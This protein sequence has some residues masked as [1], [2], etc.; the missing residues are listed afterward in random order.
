MSSEFDTL[1]E[2]KADLKTKIREQKEKAAEN[3]YDEKLI[4]AMLEHFEADIP[5]V[6]IEAQIDRHCRGLWV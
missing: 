4:D 1:D 2:L 5:E 3:E 6:M